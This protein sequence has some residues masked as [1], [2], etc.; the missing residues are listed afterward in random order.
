MATSEADAQRIVEAVERAGVMLAVCH[1]L[2]YTAYTRA[3][4]A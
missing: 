3:L 1:V 4:A 2:R